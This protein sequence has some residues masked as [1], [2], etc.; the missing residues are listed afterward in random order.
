MADGRHLNKV[1]AQE[2][3]PTAR[4][5]L[6]AFTKLARDSDLN[7]AEHPGR[8]RQVMAELR[9]ETR[10]PLGDTHPYAVRHGDGS[11]GH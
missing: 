7:G 8:F 9:V 3:G 10:R 11:T 2:A 5:L 6:E 1:V 4:V